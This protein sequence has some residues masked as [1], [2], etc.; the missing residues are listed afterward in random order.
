MK[1]DVIKF[2]AE[3]PASRRDQFNLALALYRKSKNPDP[4]QVRYMNTLG[5]SEDR[6]E[7]LLY[8]LKKLHG[9]TDLEIASARNK[10]SKKA[11]KDKVSPEQQLL[12]EVQA[13]DGITLQPDADIKLSKEYFE[14]LLARLE[15]TGIPDPDKNLEPVIEIL[16]GFEASIQS[17]ETEANQKAV[18]EAL[19]KAADML[20]EGSEKDI[21]VNDAEEVKAEAATIAD[22]EQPV[23]KEGKSDLVEKLESFDVEA[24]SYNSIKSF[25]AD[26]SDVTGEDPADQKKV[27]LKAFVLAA[28]KKLI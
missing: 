19:D 2:L 24:E 15:E 4:S 27:T 9:V 11:K 10:P 18:S 6:L 13:L 22:D 20:K 17:F 16:K 23:K 14:Q 25:A 1:N 3:K 12:E 21:E 26:V 5:F 28:K 7:I 8:E